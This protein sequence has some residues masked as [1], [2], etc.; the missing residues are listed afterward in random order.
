MG[1]KRVSGERWVKA[2]RAPKISAPE[3]PQM[4]AFP[5]TLDGSAFPACHVS[6]QRVLGPAVGK[7]ETLAGSAFQC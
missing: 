1:E 7:A 5:E 3:T 2:P 4:V 6:K